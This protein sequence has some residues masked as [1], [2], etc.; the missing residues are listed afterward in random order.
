[1]FIIYKNSHSQNMFIIFTSIACTIICIDKLSP[2]SLV[3][4]DI[5]PQIIGKAS[6]MSCW[7]LQGKFSGLM[8]FTT[9]AIDMLTYDA[10]LDKF[11]SFSCQ[12]PQLFQKI[13]LP[14]QGGH[15]STHNCKY[16]KKKAY[17]HQ[18]FWNDLGNL[19][20]LL[21]SQKAFI[22]VLVSFYQH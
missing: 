4:L 17:L 7:D 10:V 14:R 21:G 18:S 3:K 19:T 16:K 20:C 2:R 9:H 13:G 5:R 15:Y 11:R 22:P 8:S 1:M 6:S 12:W